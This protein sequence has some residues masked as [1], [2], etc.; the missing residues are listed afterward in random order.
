MH[1][2]FPGT[3]FICGCEVVKLS[4]NDFI[5]LF[6]YYAIFNVS[7]GALPWYDFC[8]IRQILRKMPG[9]KMSFLF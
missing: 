1:K 3:T 5:A 9:Q 2:F 7:K 4:Y 8:H 6:I